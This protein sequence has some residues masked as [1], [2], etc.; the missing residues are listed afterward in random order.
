MLHG[1][2]GTSLRKMLYVLATTKF[3]RLGFP[4]PTRARIPSW[5]LSTGNRTTRFLTCPIGFSLALGRI[6]SPM[7]LLWLRLYEVKMVICKLRQETKSEDE[8][9][10]ILTL[11]K[12]RERKKWQR[13][14]GNLFPKNRPWAEWVWDVGMTWWTKLLHAFTIEFL[15]FPSSLTYFLP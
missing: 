5:G 15:K 10:E 4:D 7:S 11:T 6:F 14:T 3:G 1:Q 12:K 8:N 2:K 9:C 13:M